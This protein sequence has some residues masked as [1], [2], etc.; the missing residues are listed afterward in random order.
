MAD[1]SLRQDFIDGTFEV[2]STLFNSG[3]NNEGLSLY[4]ITDNE[5]NVY[6]EQKYKRYKSPITLACRVNISPNT[7][8]QDVQNPSFNAQFVVPLKSFQ[9][10]NLEVDKESLE[11]YR[12][13][14]VG[15]KDV[16]YEVVSINPKTYIQDCYLFYD[17]SCKELKHMEKVVIDE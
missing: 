4:L 2:I 5:T 8:V 11:L 3:E 17:F 9:I 12:R 15:F 7:S 6:G 10:N 14:L 1:L 16:L 13:S